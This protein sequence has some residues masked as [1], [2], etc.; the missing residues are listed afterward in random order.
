M[1]N[2]TSVDWRVR[3]HGPLEE[4]FDKVLYRDSLFPL[5]WLWLPFV[6]LHCCFV[7]FWI[8]IHAVSVQVLS[9]GFDRQSRA[10]SFVF[11]ISA[12]LKCI[13]VF[14][15]PLPSAQRLRWSVGHV[16]HYRRHYHRHFRRH[17]RDT[18]DKHYRRSFLE[19]ASSIGVYTSTHRAGRWTE[20][21]DFL[22]TPTNKGKRQTDT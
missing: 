6:Y 15:R 4:A 11:G 13:Y 21:E 18:S 1:D 9:W 20:G 19:C 3:N 16:R 22:L 7:M 8:C 17:W 2:V 12:I 5:S 10:A 14:S